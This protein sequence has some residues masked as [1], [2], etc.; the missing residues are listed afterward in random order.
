MIPSFVV[1]LG[2][3]CLVALAT[4]PSWGGAGE[5]PA[6]N[7]DL[8]RNL[9]ARLSA[10][11]FD[12][13]LLSSLYGQDRVRFDSDTVSVFFMHSEARLDYGQFLQ[14]EALEDARRYMETHAAALAAAQ[15]AFAVDREIVTAI[16]LVETRL[17]VYLGKRGVLDTLSTMAA[18]VDERLRA[19]LWDA[20]PPERRLSKEAYAKKAESKS[21]WAYQ[22]LKAF[23]AY[24]AR[25]GVSPT[26]IRGSYA[27][28]VG[29]SQFLPSNI[30]ALGRDGNN[31]G[32]ID[33][34][35]HA[36]AIMSVAHYLHVAGWRPEIGPEK[37][38]RAIL[39]Y[40][41]SR[42]YA[43]TILQIAELLKSGCGTGTGGGESPLTGEPDL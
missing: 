41:R 39:R 11:G 6:R 43:Q 21:R 33:L 20:I 42:P 26:E 4:A 27:G 5:I 24:T 14:P 35:D 37:A 16:L 29:I 18:L 22:E 30:L 15:S 3:A 36:D 17:G 34:F 10:D 40:N 9:T 19:Y 2:L 32:R 13:G 23:L 7:A 8:F 31:D 28:A 25:E 38:Y 12:E 1:R